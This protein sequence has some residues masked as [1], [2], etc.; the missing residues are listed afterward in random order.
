L[1]PLRA[2]QVPQ[3]PMRVGACVTTT[4]KDIETRLV[5]GSTGQPIP[6]SGSA[7]AFTNGGYQVSYDTV[8]AVENSKA[9]DPVR[10][11]L[12]SIPKGCPKGDDRGKVY[13]TTNLRTQQSWSLPDAEHMCGG[14]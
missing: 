5:D 9:G 8:P 7:V 10:M 12:V 13:K 14:A 2:A 6:G 3:L 1:T 11:C 4:I